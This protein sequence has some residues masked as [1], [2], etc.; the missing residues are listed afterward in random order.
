MTVKLSPVWGGGA[1]IFDNNG[2]KLS[3]GKIYTYSAGTT[4]PAATYTSANGLVYNA[5]PIILNSAGRPPNEIWLPDNVAYKFILKDSNDVLIATYDDLTGVNSGLSASNVTFTGVKGQTGTV[6]SLGTMNGSDYVGFQPLGS[7]AN[8]ANYSIQ[9]RLRQSVSVKDFGAVGDGITDDTNAFINALVASKNVF[10]PA[11]TYKTTAAITLPTY[12]CLIGAGIDN[13][14]IV[15]SLNNVAFITGQYSQLRQMKI[16]SSGAHLK[17]LIE[18]GSPTASGARGDRTVLSSLWVQ[19]AGADGITL[20]GGNLGVIENVVCVSNGANGIRFAK[21]S[22]DLNN[23][24]LQGFIDLRGNGVDGLQLEA[25]ASWTSNTNS[26]QNIITN[27]TC[28]NNTRYGLYIGTKSNLIQCY[29]EANGVKDIYIASG[30]RG[31][32]ITSVIGIIQDDSDEPSFNTVYVD[33]AIAGYQRA[34]K[35]LSWFSGNTAAGLGLL[36]DDLTAGTLQFHK[37]AAREYSMTAAGSNATQTFKF[38]N[39]VAGFYLNLNVDGIVLPARDN[40]HV[41][42]T[43]SFRWSVVYA[44]T[45]TINTSDRDKKEQIEALSK[46]EKIVAL[47]IKKAVKKFKFKDAV[48][49]K[50]SK[51]RIHVGVIAQEVAEIFAKNGLNAEDYGLFCSDK[52]DDGSVLLGIRYEELLAFII[53]AL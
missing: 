14:N 27:L 47:Q 52:L 31:N 24:T 25:D 3:G 18:V 15:A 12:G 46:A 40:V 41:L 23:W 11:G 6:A 20:Y 34:S 42:G 19:G 10:V 43:A 9:D 26:R 21:G 45:G 28:Q 5:N 49:E 29:C 13:T 22:T 1:Q 35:N 37:T 44:A 38:D 32:S 7:G 4:T 48:A 53:G 36:N 8:Y 30:A 33:N 50:G 17:N 51:A 2:V 39:S 16:L